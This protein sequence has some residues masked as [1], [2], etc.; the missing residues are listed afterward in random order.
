MVLS[1]KKLKQKLRAELAQN[2]NNADVVVDAPTS[3]SCSHS[4]KTLLDSATHKPR[5]SKREKRRKLGSL[6]HPQAETSP[7]AGDEVDGSKKENGSE[8]LSSKKNKKRKR[9]VEDGDVANG[10]LND[11]KKSKNKNKNK[12]QKQKQKT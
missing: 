12:K 11:E 1:N 2:Q 8:G 10:V 5:F 6:Q 4:L 3:S 7:E 9:K